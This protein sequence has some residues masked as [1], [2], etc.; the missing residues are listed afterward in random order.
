[1]KGWKTII[2]SMIIAML[3]VAETADW[4]S[5]LGDQWGGVVLLVVG[6]ISAWLRK[7][8]TTPLGVKE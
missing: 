8:T 7:L 2:F 5:V 1:M 6:V 3:G 4:I